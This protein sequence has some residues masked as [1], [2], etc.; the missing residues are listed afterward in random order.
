MDWLHLA[1]NPLAFWI[2]TWVEEH[3]LPKLWVY[4]TMSFLFT[5]TTSSYIIITTSSA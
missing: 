1:A 3:Q 5:I 2:N 4:F